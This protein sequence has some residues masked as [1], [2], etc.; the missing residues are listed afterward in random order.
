MRDWNQEY[1]DGRWNFLDNPDE[2][3][4]L[5]CVAGFIAAHAPGEV[6]DLGSGKGRL[7]NYARPGSISRYVAVDVARSA[8]DEVPP[9]PFPIE[10]HCLS[11]EEFTPEKR[12]VGT[13]VASEVLYFLDNPAEHVA[14]IAD[15]CETLEAVVVSLLAP[16]P[17]KPNWC[18]AAER[19]WSGFN[20]LG[21]ARHQSVRVENDSKGT[22]WDV[23]LFLRGA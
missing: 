10:T 4:R 14:R 2:Q 11:I 17:E 7:L 3:V 16:N 15:A 9:A 13:L 22:G 20:E 18:R 5:A 1:V 12:A 8:L 23:V 21:W 19:V 6:I